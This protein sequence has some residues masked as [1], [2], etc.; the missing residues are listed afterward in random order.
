MGHA[1]S[2]YYPTLDEV[3]Q[4]HQLH[5][6]TARP[7][8]GLDVCWL[9]VTC[10]C[11]HTV[12]VPAGGAPIDLGAALEEHVHSEWQLACT[13]SDRQDLEALPESSIID[14]HGAIGV[15]AGEVWYFAGVAAPF[16]P[17]LP[18]LLVR[19]GNGL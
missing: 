11:Q 2:R 16:E 9:D 12:S 8:D 4:Q 15:R 13:V 18:V 3:G 6:V 7:D 5:G 1:V 14:D 17:N 19:F 10:T